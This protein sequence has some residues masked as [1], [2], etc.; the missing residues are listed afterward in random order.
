VQRNFHFGIDIPARD[1]TPVYAVSPG[2]VYLSPDRVAVLTTARPGHRTGFTYWHITPAVPEDSF[3]GLHALI[4]WIKPGLGHVHFAEIE[5]NRYVNPLRPGA[6]TPAPNL[7]R[8]TIDSI[9]VEPIGPTAEADGAVDGTIRV[10]VETYVRPKETPLPPWQG[11]V[12]SPSLIRWRLLAHGTPVSEWRTAVDFRNW[13][14]PN[15]RYGDIYAP[16][17]RPDHPDKPGTFL[18]YLA[19]KWNA[20]SLP[21][22]TYTIKVVAY[23]TGRQKTTATFPLQI[24][25]EMKT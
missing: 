14:P 7:R 8:P 16:A 3:V 17:A 22:G 24:A 5:H 10:V 20:A 21:H 2:I 4:G 1:G 25:K 19:R 9:T 23:S 15:S 12:I 6:L 18:Y 11:S 13:I